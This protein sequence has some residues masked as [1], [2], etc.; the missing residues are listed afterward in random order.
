MEE[1]EEHHTHEKGKETRAQYSKPDY[2]GFTNLHD[3][4]Q[5]ENKHLRPKNHSEGDSSSLFTY[6]QENYTKEARTRQATEEIDK[7]KGK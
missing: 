6:D 3:K 7:P 4:K 5:K 1:F 2:E